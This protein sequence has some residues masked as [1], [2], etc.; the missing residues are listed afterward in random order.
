MN[1]CILAVSWIQ[2]HVCLGLPQSLCLT[3]CQLS[4]ERKSKYSGWKKIENKNPKHYTILKTD[5]DLK[6]W[7][8]GPVCL[9]PYAYGGKKTHGLVSKLCIYLCRLNFFSRDLAKF[10]SKHVRIQA[11]VIKGLGAAAVNRILL[12]LFFPITLAGITPAEGFINHFL[13]Q[14]LI[15][16]FPCH[17]CISFLVM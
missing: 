12:K 2:L 6:A 1:V 3:S 17:C 5:V 14:S 16:S 9:R 13:W 7:N 4:M 10:H 11:G 8:P 15:L